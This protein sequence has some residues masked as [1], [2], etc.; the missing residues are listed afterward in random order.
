VTKKVEKEEPVPSAKFTVLLRR[1]ELER[2]AK[3]FG[4]NLERMLEL[5]ACEP[6]QAERGLQ[7]YECELADASLD[8]SSGRFK[9][10]FNPYIAAVFDGKTLDAFTR[11]KSL[12]LG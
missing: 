12:T 7:L 4:V 6:V 10:R 1:E 3:S 8:E 9:M 2:L 5:G 11:V